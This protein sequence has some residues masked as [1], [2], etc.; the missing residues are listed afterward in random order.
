MAYQTPGTNI[1]CPY[2]GEDA[3]LVTG[4]I[5]YPH[6]VDLYDKKFWHCEPCDAYVGCHQQGAYV[7]INRQK[8]TSDGSLP[9]GRLA[10]ADLRRAKTIAHDAFDPMWRRY[11]TH[12]RRHAYKWLA[13]QMGM[14]QDDCHIG[15]FDV[16][17][18]M[19]VV[20]VVNAQRGKPSPF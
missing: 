16:K 6:R 11:G 5:I 9:L 18:C 19:Q 4:R 13:S 20:K 10:N 2:C 15:E 14:T 3:H 1:K 17:Q 7:Y 8:V 12:M